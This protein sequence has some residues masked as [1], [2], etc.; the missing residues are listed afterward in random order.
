[1]SVSTVRE[2]RRSDTRREIL[3]AAVEV[4]TERGVAGLSLSEVAR[5]VGMRQPSL[6]KHF[7]SLHAVYDALFHEAAVAQLA[8]VRGAADQG[9]LAVFEAIGRLAMRHPV[10]GQL[11]AWRPVPSFHP[12]PEA[13]QPSIDMVQEVRAV[14]RAA[15]EDGTL[16]PAA[17]SEEGVA[18]V[19]IL[20]TGTLSQQL[21]NEPEASYED[22]RFTRLVPQVVAMFIRHYAPEK[23]S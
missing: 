17:D 20:V 10:L 13:F 2:R 21:A 8:A 4:M 14:L 12:S 18:L 5:R 16:H 23:R 19:S 7:A 9:L 3:D 6:Y 11:L 22:G 15:V 1:M